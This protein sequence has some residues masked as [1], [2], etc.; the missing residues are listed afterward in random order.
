MRTSG[1]ETI[2]TLVVIAIHNHGDG[3]SNILAVSEYCIYGL[4][5]PLIFA[6]V[7]SGAWFR[8]KRQRR[9]T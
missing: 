4:V 3:A 1:M 5:C 2:D 6:E 8:I 9:P 7:G